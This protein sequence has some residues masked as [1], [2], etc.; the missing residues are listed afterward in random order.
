MT[1]TN[2]AGCASRRRHF[3]K[4]EIEELVM[5]TSTLRPGLLISLKTSIRGNVHYD[6]RDLQREHLT[7]AGAKFAKWETSRTIVDPAEYETATKVRS[8]ARSIISGI[9]A[10]SAFGLLCPENAA[11]NLEQAI[12]EARHLVAGFNNAAKVTRLDVYIMP[13]RIASDEVEA[14]AAINS[15]VRDLL[16]DMVEGVSN[17][18]VKLIRDAAD[19]ARSLGQMLSPDA[20]GRLQVAIDVARAEARRIKA[21]ETATLEVDQRAIRRINE[22]RTTFQDLDPALDVAES[23]VDRRSHDAHSHDSEHVS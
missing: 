9:C 17:L 10:K 5:Q 22:T 7:E 8:R 1:A 3:N 11:V 21:G 16:A 13:G 6:K 12:A 20:Q 23:T 14:V 18:D 2:A 15:E 19:R 4:T